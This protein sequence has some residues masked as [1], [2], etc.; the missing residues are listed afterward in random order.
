MPVR[1]YYDGAPE[2]LTYY[3]VTAPRPPREMVTFRLAPT[4]L[5]AVRRVADENHNGNRSDALRA[6]LRLG[7][8]AYRAGKR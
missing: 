2:R 8:D 7:L 1:A 6:L 3:A 5:A 4:A